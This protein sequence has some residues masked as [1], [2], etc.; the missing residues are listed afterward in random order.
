MDN[1]RKTFHHTL[2]EI[3]QEM[4]QMAALVTEGIPR[5]TE[6]LL[7]GDLGDAQA[8]IEGDDPLDAAAVELEERCYQQLALQQPMAGDLRSLVTAIRMI[9]E[10]ERSG[11]LVVNIAKGSRRI[12]GTELS[13]RLRG[14]IGQMGEEATRLFRL[15]MD[16]YID[17]DAGVAAALDDLDDRL[18]AIH[19]DYIQEIFLVH[20]SGTL[21]VQAAVQLALIGRY[22]ERIG[23]HAVNIGERV[24]Y[25]VTGWLPEH[26]GAA[27]NAARN[28]PPPRS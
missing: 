16:S 24:R 15:A 4:V 22:Y 23:D 1:V 20:N 25:M 3:R 8:I 5:A 13:A 6:T 26:T 10:I 18:D 12:F 28:E 11:D 9:A 14:L 2:E 17:E 27:R 21:S 19:R 7:A